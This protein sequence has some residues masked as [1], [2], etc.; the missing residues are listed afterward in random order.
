MLLY[1]IELNKKFGYEKIAV[2]NHSFPNTKEYN[3]LFAKHSHILQIYQLKYVPNFVSQS[4]TNMSEHEHIYLT[5]FNDM[6]WSLTVPLEVLMYNQCYM[7]HSDTYKYI[8]ING[9]DELIIPR[10]YPALFREQDTVALVT[11]LNMANINDKRA[12]SEALN[13]TSVISQNKLLS[14]TD[15]NCNIIH[16]TN[17]L[18]HK[19]FLFLFSKTF[20]PFLLAHT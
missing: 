17:S 19:L 4:T 9:A 18:I 3:E 15:N 10:T 7:D 13:V 8:S 20:S 1:W 6:H 11:G 2:C 16:N 12:L 5:S 14:H